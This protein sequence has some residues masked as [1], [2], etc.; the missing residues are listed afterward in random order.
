MQFTACIFDLDGTLLDTAD[1]VVGTLVEVIREHGFSG[2]NV[3]SSIV[4]G[5]P[6]SESIARACPDADE[7]TAASIL[8]E[9]RAR[10]N[11]ST[12]PNTRFYPGIVDLLDGLAAEGIP[13]F[14]ATNKIT[15]PAQRVLKHFHILDRFA[16]AIS[17]DHEPGR[18]LSKCDMIR[19]LVERH[20]LDERTTVM[21]GDTPLDI[22]GGREAGVLTMA[23]LYGY[24]SRESLLA[25]RPHFL[26]ET[27][28]WRHSFIPHP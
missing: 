23:A 17:M 8:T 21:I 7:A 10:Y 12:Y 14:V 19:T 25:A 18:T 6:L 4:V 22:N 16:E 11:V 2:S 24:G 1:D 15:E 3:T 27:P 26:T 9:Y 28:D 20:Q 13:L 5:P